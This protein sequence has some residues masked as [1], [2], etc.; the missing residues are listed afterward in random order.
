MAGFKK[1]IVLKNNYTNDLSN[2]MAVVTLEQN[3]SNIKANIKVYNLNM[4]DDLILGISCNG[5]EIYN[6]QLLIN[7]SNSCNIDIYSNCNIN[8][9]IS[10]VI[11]KKYADNVKAVVW[12]SNNANAT[13]K[14]EFVNKLN[15]K[16]QDKSLNGLTDVNF[17]SV[18]VYENKPVNNKTL[19]MEEMFETSDSEIEEII[20]ENIEG[21]FYSLI[22]DQ[23]DELF[24][25]FPIDNRLSD[26]IPGSK[27]VKVN[28]EPNSNEYVV[29][30]IYEQQKVKY[31]CYGVPSKYSNKVPDEIEDFSQWIPLNINK[32]F[33]DGF[34]LMFQDALTGESVK[35]INDAV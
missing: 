15:L 24:N 16:H 6:K 11:V 25:K 8:S 35:L 1:R 28:Y 27:W 23:L 31:I 22:K 2:G 14:E 3:A 10:C 26:L 18:E 29:G 7:K 9:T 4:S 21:D 13:Y 17:E 32:P 30:L 5:K 33:E 20:D 12:G 19:T 34:Y